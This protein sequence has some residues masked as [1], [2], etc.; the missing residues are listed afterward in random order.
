[1]KGFRLTSIALFSLNGQLNQI[2]PFEEKVFW[3]FKEKAYHFY[4]VV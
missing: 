4:L 2:S 1:M 3:I